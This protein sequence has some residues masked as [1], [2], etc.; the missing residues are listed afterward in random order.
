ME[1]SPPPHP[2]SGTGRPAGAAALAQP[3][4]MRDRKLLMQRIQE[5]GPTEHAEIFKM[6]SDQGV[7]YTQ[8]SNGIFVNL[9]GVPSALLGE[10]STFVSF[11]ID[12]NHSLNEYDKRLS[13]CKINSAA[14]ADGGAAGASTSCPADA[15]GAS[16]AA[17]GAERG[18]LV[19]EGAALPPQPAPGGGDAP[20]VSQQPQ[21][22]QQPG[23]LP[24]GQEP[25]AGQPT[26][27]PRPAPSAPIPIASAQFIDKKV[28][29]MRFAQAK[30][31]YA[32]RRVPDKRADSGVDST[33]NNLLPE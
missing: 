31:K 22:L 29:Q 8:N 7:E 13:E 10:L 26:E 28:E 14:V 1:M 21:D 33:T 16:G 23:V 25:Q 4:T 12:N 20:E 24:A 11:C 30:K 17:S 3:F 15:G 32:K 5:L 2:P 9:S 27:E 19:V 18:G 6:L